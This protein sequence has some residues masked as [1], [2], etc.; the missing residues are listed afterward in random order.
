MQLQGNASLLGVKLN[1]LDLIRPYQAELLRRRMDP[2][3]IRRRMVRTGSEWERLA[4]RL[5]DELQELLDRLANGNLG[6]TVNLEGIDRTANRLA[7]T[8]LTTALFTG[9]AR[10][11]AQGVPPRTRSGMSIPGAAGTVAAGLV[12]VSVLRA[13][14]RSGGLG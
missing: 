11:W 10:L 2:S 9:S 5:P 3:R 7:V 14:R 8:A 6:G 12:A 13:A 4:A 1:L